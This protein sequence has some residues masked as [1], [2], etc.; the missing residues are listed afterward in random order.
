MN[1]FL[2]SLVAGQQME[3]Y[4][5]HA[6]NWNIDE[7]RKSRDSLYQTLY[8]KC[9]ILDG[10]LRIELD[11]GKREIFMQMRRELLR[12]MGR[13]TEESQ[14]LDKLDANNCKGGRN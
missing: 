4:E 11:E 10:F 3:E 12:Y 9:K 2:L 7:T 5:G 14:L 6:L 1:S 8:V 13:V